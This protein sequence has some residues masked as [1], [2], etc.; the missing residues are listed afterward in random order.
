E[1]QQIAEVLQEQIESVAASA[2][3]CGND[4]VSKRMV[5]V[6]A[7]NKAIKAKSVDPSISTL[8]NRFISNYAEHVPTKK[9][10][11][12]AGVQSGSSHRINCWINETVIVP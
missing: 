7:L 8:A 5:Y 6:A 10:L 1:Q 4:V 2:N 3:S 11:F 9:D 12:V